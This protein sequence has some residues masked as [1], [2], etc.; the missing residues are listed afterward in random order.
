[1]LP[2]Q[3]GRGWKMLSSM[4]FAVLVLGAVFGL[5]LVS[6]CIVM[7]LAYALVK[8]GSRAAYNAIG[9][10]FGSG[11]KVTMGEGVMT[12]RQIVPVLELATAMGEFEHRFDWKRESLR[13]LGIP[14]PFSSKEAECSHVYV[15]KSGFDLRDQAC[16][17]RF[18]PV[19]GVSFLARLF[20]GNRLDVHVAIPKPMILSVESL[21]MRIEDRSG[22]IEFWNALSE[23]DRHGIAS[24]MFSRSRGH[25]AKSGRCLMIEAMQRLESGLRTVL[26]VSVG[27]VE[28]EWLENPR[29]FDFKYSGENWELPVKNHNEE[30]ANEE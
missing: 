16:V 11:C 8:D 5:G 30:L 13:L 6:V 20:G 24:E 22:W 9:R 2:F 1:M 17:F 25:I 27:A 26:P 21:G 29:A 3:Q 10:F 4:A 18:T 12:V 23:E 14:V 28:V 7:L 19:G 15:A